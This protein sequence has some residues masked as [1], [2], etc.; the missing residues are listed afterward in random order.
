MTRTASVSRPASPASLCSSRGSVHTTPA[1]APMHP[2]CHARSTPQPCGHVH[3]AQPYSV[4]VLSGV[5][6]LRR[7]EV[8]GQRLGTAMKATSGKQPCQ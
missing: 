4:R 3:G 7:A 8:G 1:P 6:R 5:Q 2:V